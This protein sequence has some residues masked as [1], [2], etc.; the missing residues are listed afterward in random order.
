MTD[1]V[2][3]VIN[4]RKYWAYGGKGERV[5]EERRATGW[6]LAPES[7]PVHAGAPKKRDK[8]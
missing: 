4:W 3:K 7:R 1:Y 8:P 5:T 6:C 2:E